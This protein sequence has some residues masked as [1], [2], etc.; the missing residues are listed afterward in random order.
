MSTSK[1]AF[2]IL[3]GLLLAAAHLPGQAPTSKL[4]G[5]VSDE[6]GNPLPGVAIQATSPKLVGSGKAVSDENGVY[7]IFA[8]TPGVYRVTFTL[9]G[10]KTVTRDG[11][12]VELE[13]SVKLNVSMPLGAIEEE[14]TVVGQSPLIDVKS[15]VKTQD[16]R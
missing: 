13:H 8:L 6:Q 1:K 4:F 12:I 2:I 7:R 16:C 5:A 9:Q 10:F 11:I 15:T 14:V 3:L